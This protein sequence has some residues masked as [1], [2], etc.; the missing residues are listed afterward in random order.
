MVK[1]DRREGFDQKEKGSQEAEEQEEKEQ[2]PYGIRIIN[3]EI[4][5]ISVLPNM[6]K[7]I[8]EY[9]VQHRLKEGVKQKT[10]E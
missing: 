6:P 7:I 9:S 5:Y 4:T 2:D 3:K 8:L 1:I 10:K